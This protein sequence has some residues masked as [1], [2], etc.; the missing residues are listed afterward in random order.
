MSEDNDSYRI[1]PT[2]DELR[3]A[4]VNKLL[5]K[6]VIMNEIAAMDMK[7]DNLSHFIELLDTELKDRHADGT[8]DVRPIY[9]KLRGEISALMC[10][11]MELE[12]RRDDLDKEI[13]DLNVDVPNMKVIVKRASS[14]FCVGQQFF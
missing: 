12:Q 11:Q 1:M 8:A 3:R 10:K 13:E 7:I 2:E 4:C 14:T 5:E 9:A 6:T